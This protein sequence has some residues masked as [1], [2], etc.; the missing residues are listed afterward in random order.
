MQLQIPE[1]EYVTPAVTT[2]MHT[3]ERFLAI[4][5]ETFYFGWVASA[6]RGLKNK[7]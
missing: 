1:K 6:G 2:C 5:F 3:Y 4:S 7:V